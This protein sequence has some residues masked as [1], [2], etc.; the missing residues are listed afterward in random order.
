MGD[1]IVKVKMIPH[2]DRLRGESGINTLIRKYFE[3]LPQHDI[4]LVSHDADD[5][6]VLAVHAGM[7]DPGQAQSAAVVSHLHGLYWTADYNSP[8]WEYAA[9]RNV[10]ASIRVADKVTVPS[11][12]VAKT[13]QRDMRL[14]PIVLPHGIDADEWHHDGP[15][16]G[17]VL[18]NKNRAGDVCDPSPVTVLARRFAQQSFVTTFATA[19]AKNIH[20]IGVRPH[21]EMRSIVKS[22]GVYLATTKETFGIGIL[23]AMAAGKPVLGYDHGG[24]VDIVEHGVNGYL[25]TPGDLDDLTRGL[26]YCL[27]HAET[28]GHNGRMLADREF[29]WDDIALRC[30]QIYQS[31]MR[32]RDSF[33]SG[34]VTF[35]IPCHNY[36]DKV[37][38]AISSALNQTDS[39]SVEEVIV[40]DNNSTDNSA[41]IVRQISENNPKVK[42]LFEPNPG[43]A[44]A[45]NAGV[46]AASGRFITCLDADD[47][48]EPEWVQELLPALKADRSL[49]VAYS[50]LRWV[51]GDGTT[52]ISQWPGEYRYDNFLKKQNQVPTCCMFRKDMWRSLG[53]YRQRY[54]P[55]GA[56]AEDAE[57]FLRAGAYGWGGKLA[58]EKP[59]FI[60]SWGTGLVSGNKEYREVNWLE[61]HP[62]IEDQQHPMASMAT[63]NRISHPVRQ[64]DEPIVSIIIPVGS[65]HEQYVIDALD[66]LESQTYRKWEAIIAWDSE[67]SYTEIR[68]SYPYVEFVSV[69]PNAG[70]GVARNRGVDVASG[71]LLLFLDADDYIVSGKSLE[72]MVR[73]YAEHQQIVYSDYVGAAIV[74]DP[75]KLASQLQQR[76]LHRDEK[77]G[78]TIIRY[79][80]K[81]YDC[82]RAKEPW[83]ENP[84]YLWC[85]ITSLVPRA[86]H[87]QIGGFDES[88]QSWEDIDYWWRMSWAG[89]CFHR[90][91]QPLLLYRFHTGHRRETGRQAHGNLLDYIRHKEV[92]KVP[93]GG[94]GGSRAP[95]QLQPVRQP[96]SVHGSQQAMDDSE[97]VRI[98]YDARNIGFHAVVGPVTKTNYGYK[99]KGDQFI[100]A[101]VDQRHSPER[102]RKIEEKIPV[103]DPE[104]KSVA[105]PQKIEPPPPKF[106]VEDIPGIGPVTAR[107]M[108]AKGFDNPKAIVYAGVDEL[109]NVK[110]LNHARAVMVVEY[111]SE[112]YDV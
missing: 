36:G 14:N 41:A 16:Q 110:G 15:S 45:R 11:A 112:N 67:L 77:T 7:A 48:V 63:P 19:E 18:W 20:V 2:R 49:G 30:A 96:L 75:S 55:Q 24:I 35:V 106:D 102:F 59:L 29:N 107:A 57:F 72:E 21:E 17:F 38:R 52:D 86:W 95:R 31:A 81:D 6:D 58:T 108:R 39:D 40:V 85:N 8:G 26:E 68:E 80:A 92:D 74:E 105:A 87:Y 111:V 51:R 98:E 66:S 28:L 22:C 25:A 43:V 61:W 84:P 60:Y 101:M 5:F 78:M 9:N 32:E 99:R 50:R 13:L 90:I 89:K 70:A 3:Y 79:G 34:K 104:P 54:A 46:R 12:W 64:Y 88:M 94:C 23:E 10:I 97:Y 69:G 33:L 1:D 44:H 62:W 27:E 4:E 47:A 37:G 71:K 76:I 42:Y 53:G 91:S 56:G 83:R 65:G 93:C 82:E 73:A 109:V 100:V 103:E